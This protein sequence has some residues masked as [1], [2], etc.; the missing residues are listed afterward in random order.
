MI[1]FLRKMFPTIYSLTKFKCLIAFTSL[2]IGQYVYLNCSF[3]NQVVI[4][5]SIFKLTFFLLKPPAISDKI[6]PGG[7]GRGTS[8]GIEKRTCGNS[9]GQLKKVKFP[10]V[11]NF[12][13]NSCGVSMGLQFHLGISNGCHTQFCKISRGESLLSQESDKF[14]NS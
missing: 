7:S 9:R 5:S 14:K 2:N 11:L 12:K 8:K 13:K 4:L 10:G 3:V 6:W 1:D